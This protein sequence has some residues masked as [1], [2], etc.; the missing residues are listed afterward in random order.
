MNATLNGLAL[1]FAAPTP[2]TASAAATAASA[3]IASAILLPLILLLP[4]IR[5]CYGG[6]RD[7]MRSRP[8][9]LD[10]FEQRLPDCLLGAPREVDP[11]VRAPPDVLALHRRA[12]LLVED[13]AARFGHLAVEEALNE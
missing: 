4:S 5:P 11:A 2:D 13:R 6:N 7:Y 9:G 10:T 12:W 3:T 1:C 8:P